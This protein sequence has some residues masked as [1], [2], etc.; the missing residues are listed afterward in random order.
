MCIYMKNMKNYI[1]DM[2]ISPNLELKHD[3]GGN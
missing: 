2:S 3:F 1:F